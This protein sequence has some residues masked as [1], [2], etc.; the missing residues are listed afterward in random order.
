MKIYIGIQ[1]RMTSSRLPGKVLKKINGI[2]LIE[3]LLKRLSHLPNSFEIFILTSNDKSDDPIVNF[4]EKNKINFF[5]GSLTNVFSR[6]K[7]FLNKKFGQAVIR[8][9]G[10]SPMIDYK[11][12][13][14]MTSIFKQSEFDILTNIFPR[15]FPSGQ[16]VEIIS[17]KALNYSTKN[18]SLSELEHVTPFFYNNH[19]KFKIYNLPCP[20]VHQN[21]KLSI[22]EINDFNKFERLVKKVGKNFFKLSVK[23]IMSIWGK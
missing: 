8:I 15:S 10:D 3:Y 18:I 22:D 20:Y 5:R 9:S 1:A 4:C 13:E 7:E 19:K 17:T 23:E 6:Y 12:I 11:L 21:L 14:Q 2:P 16:S